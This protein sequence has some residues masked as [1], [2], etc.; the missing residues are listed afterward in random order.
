MDKNKINH[1][2]KIKDFLYPLKGVYSSLFLYPQNKIEFS[3]EVNY[4]KYWEDKRGSS[5][6]N[7]S[8]WQKAR[9]DIVLDSIKK[10]GDSLTDVGC[11]DGSVLNYLKQTR[12]DLSLRGVDVSELALGHAKKKGIETL[13]INI[14][15]LNEVNKINTSDYFLL[16]EVLE[17]LPAPELLLKSIHDKSQKG[18]F[19]SFPNSGYFIYRL[20]LFFGKF[21]AQWRINPGEHLRFWT[22]SDLKW[23][24]NSLGYKKYEISYYKGVVILNKILPSLFAAGFVVFLPVRK[25]KNNENE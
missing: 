10:K 18:V 2:K 11:G 25:L 12:E 20:R 19:F 1:W 5:L 14:N 23:W 17:H 13:R 24:L 4:D 8:S 6:G 22:N 21:P 16:L 3:E 15:D 9:A 7:L